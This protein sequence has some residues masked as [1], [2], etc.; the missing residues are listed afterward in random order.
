MYCK[1]KLRRAARRRARRGAGRARACARIHCDARA[2]AGRRGRGGTAVPTS[3]AA[4]RSARATR[5]RGSFGR[6]RRRNR[7][8]L[9]ASGARR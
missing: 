6:L 3:A 2:T 1:W 9:S 4:R 5:R 8:R 7:L